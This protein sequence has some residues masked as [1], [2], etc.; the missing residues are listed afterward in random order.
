MALS[1]EGLPLVGYEPEYENVNPVCESFYE[2]ATTLD[3]QATPLV[4]DFG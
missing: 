2:L 3:P 1:V 4:R